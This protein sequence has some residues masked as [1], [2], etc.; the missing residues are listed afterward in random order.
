M[1]TEGGH[2]EDRIL[3]AVADRLEREAAE[4]DQLLPRPSPGAAPN[5]SPR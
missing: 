3:L 1:P 2:E 5:G 4:L